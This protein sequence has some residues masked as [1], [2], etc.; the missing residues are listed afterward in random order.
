MITTEVVT[1]P[2]AQYEQFTRES[3]SLHKRIYRTHLAEAVSFV[4]VGA[5]KPMLPA[6]Q[7]RARREGGSRAYWAELARRAY[8]SNP[9]GW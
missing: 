6:Q 4:V 5:Y 3:T 9:K 8:S 1:T 2:R 7:E